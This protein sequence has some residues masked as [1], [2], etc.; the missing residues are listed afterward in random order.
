MR[1]EVKVV[2]GAVTYTEKLKIAGNLRNLSST[3]L[4]LK[5]L[6]SM[7]FFGV[8]FADASVKMLRASSLVT[9]KGRSKGGS[10]RR[11]LTK[12]KQLASICIFEH[13]LLF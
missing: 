1:H 5:A 4:A 9:R 7:T 11:D 6:K 13:L 12:G 10:F 8:H 3:Y 2:P